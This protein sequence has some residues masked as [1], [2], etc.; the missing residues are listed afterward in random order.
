MTLS[1]GHTHDVNLFKEGTSYSLTEKVLVFVD[2]VYL[3]I[4]KF[5]ENSFIH[6]KSSKNHPLIEEVK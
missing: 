6:V 4:M 3:S 5:R 1:D 2:L